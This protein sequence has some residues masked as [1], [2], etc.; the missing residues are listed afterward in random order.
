MELSYNGSALSEGNEYKFTCHVFG[1]SP[2]PIV[3]WWVGSVL[4]NWKN[5]CKGSY[6]RRAI[7]SL[8]RMIYFKN[9]TTISTLKYTPQMFQ[10]GKK[11]ACRAENSFIKNSAIVDE[12]IL[13]VTHPPVAKLS[14]WELYGNDSISEEMYVALVCN[15]TANPDF[16]MV[17][18]KKDGNLIYPSHST[19]RNN[20]LQFWDKNYYRCMSDY[21]IIF[22][23]AT[24]GNEGSYVSE[25]L[26]SFGIGSSN[27]VNSKLVDGILVDCEYHY[28]I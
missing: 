13:N 19:C 21:E 28:C 5:P 18:W 7:Y 2:T 11:I 4:L 12:T 23:K 26:N 24:K 1:S 16:T 10:N 27:A 8:D 9:S 20:D 22:V 15:I 17:T 3:T 14:L 25:A 6:S